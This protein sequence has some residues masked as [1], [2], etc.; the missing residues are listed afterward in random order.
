MELTYWFLNIERVK[1]V[2]PWLINLKLRLTRLCLQQ[3]VLGLVKL[4]INNQ[5]FSQN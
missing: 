2:Y 5:E 3:M 4:E 1:V